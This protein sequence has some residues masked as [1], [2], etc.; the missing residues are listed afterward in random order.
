M[1]LNSVFAYKET[2]F[3]IISQRIKYSLFSFI[4]KKSNKLFLKGG[5]AL[6][7]A[8]QIFGVHEAPLTLYIK[9]LA[10][11]G[12]KDFLIDIGANIGLISC[13]NGAE[14]S[15]VHMYEPNPLCCNILEVNT[16]IALSAKTFCIHRY[17]L[18]EA[19]K[20]VSLIVP[21]HNWGGAFIKDSGNSYSEVLLASK[22]RFDSIDKDNYFQTDVLIKDAHI[23]LSALFKDLFHKGLTRGVI[24][25][26]VEGY[27]LAVLLGIANSLPAGINVFI[28]F[29]SWDDKMDLA[30]VVCAFKGRCKVKKLNQLKPWKR[31]WSGVRKFA[32]LILNPVIY[33]KVT[34]I[35]DMNYFG[36]IILEIE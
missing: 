32:S 3:Q 16:A 27:E 10:N 24:K 28:I 11:N 18:G 30:Q 9:S 1:K 20:I 5:D 33:T 35:T 15:E 26:D 34:E 8:P 25:I 4:T 7:V 36:D 23:E 13:Q 22:D 2:I 29:E 14:F 31:Q 17:G 21:K 12:Y 6:S 19:E